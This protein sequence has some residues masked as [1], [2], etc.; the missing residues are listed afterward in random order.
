MNYYGSCY[1][2]E[3]NRLLKRINTHLVRWA[4]PKYKQLWPFRKTLR[5]WTRLTQ[6]IR[7]FRLWA[8]MAQLPPG[9]E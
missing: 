8:W 1:R 6:G 7:A 3:L 2:T 5:W 9:Y 4:Q